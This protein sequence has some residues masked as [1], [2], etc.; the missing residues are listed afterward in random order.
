MWPHKKKK[1]VTIPPGKSVEFGFA[2]KWRSDK[3]EVVILTDDGPIVLNEKSELF[4]EVSAD[5]IDPIKMQIVPDFKSRTLSLVEVIDLDAKQTVGRKGKISF[6]GASISEDSTMSV[7]EYLR[8]WDENIEK[9]DNRIRSIKKRKNIFLILLAVIIPYNI[10]AFVM[11][12]SPWR[13]LNVFAVIIAIY[14]AYHIETACGSLQKE[15]D[16][17][18]ELRKKAFSTVGNV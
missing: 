13:Y 16:K 11:S 8:R 5:N 9:F 3:K 1:G 17:Y 7:D 15:Y 6:E 14:S 10:Y 18:K 4:I 2:T 12:S